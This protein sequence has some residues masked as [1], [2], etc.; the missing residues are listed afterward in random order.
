[1]SCTGEAARSRDER[2]LADP[3][4]D[5]VAIRSDIGGRLDRIGAEQLSRP[6]KQR[7]YFIQLLLQPG[8][9]HTLTLPRPALFAQFTHRRANHRG[10]SNSEVV[11]PK[12]TVGLAGGDLRSEYGA[13]AP[14]ESCPRIAEDSG[15]QLSGRLHPVG[16][17]RAVACRAVDSYR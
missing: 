17:G 11:A 3:G 8:I 16:D 1:M 2:G 13:S 7:A 10:R 15:L 6:A 4:L 9:S 14:P 5:G 12:M